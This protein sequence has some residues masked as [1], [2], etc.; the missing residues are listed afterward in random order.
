MAVGQHPEAYDYWTNL[1]SHLDGDMDRVFCGRPVHPRQLLILLPANHKQA[2]NL[3]C[4]FCVGKL[5]GTELGDWEDTGLRLLCN[6]KGSVPFHVYSGL[7]TEPTLSPYLLSFI[8]ITKSFGNH[9]GIQT[10]GTLLFGMERNSSFLSELCR[11]A[12]SGLD[13]VS[14]SIGAGT[15]K[16]YSKVKP[17]SPRLF[18]KLVEGI[19][20]LS[21]LRGTTGCPS[22][23]MTYLLDDY[24]D[25][26]DEIE[27]AIRIAK[28]ANV[29]S[30]RFSVAAPPYGLA[31]D[32]RSEAWKQ[33]ETK[34]KIYQ[35]MF[36]QYT[37]GPD[38]KPHIFY[39]DP[40]CY[41]PAECTF[42]Q[43]VYGYYQIAL[44]ADG[45]VYPC[46]GLSSN[47][48]SGLRLGTITDD[49]SEF[50]RMIVANQNPDFD[51]DSCYEAG[52][53][54]CRA[55]HFINWNWRMSQLI[56]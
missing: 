6:L 51:P 38:K 48:F 23:R 53:H 54:C 15:E 56:C 8:R 18:H 20:L 29:D 30:I 49:V 40:Y 52:A 37:S 12:T 26:P 7:Y 34:H 35:E 36:A 22:V 3:N 41:N 21:R 47:R 31:R 9:F 13:F 45:Y 32:K 24:N 16:T 2:C 55:A 33:V 44:G 1:K 39:A 17:A 46:V 11:V 25:S 5:S 43:C 50:Q 4:C 27:A 19:S 10:N 28:S 14:I 42:K